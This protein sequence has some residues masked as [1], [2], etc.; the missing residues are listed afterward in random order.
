MRCLLD[1]SSATLERGG[2]AGR[3]RGVSTGALERGGDRPVGPR[4]VRMGRKLG[5][6]ESFAFFQVGRRPRAFVGP[7][8]LIMCLRFKAILVPQLGCP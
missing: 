8:A 1:G 3:S 4:G 2:D 7:V 6:F 5:F